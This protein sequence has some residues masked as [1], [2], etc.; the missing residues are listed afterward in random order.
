MVPPVPA[1]TRPERIGATIIISVSAQRS[2]LYYNI[3]EMYI[4]MYTVYNLYDGVNV[5]VLRD[6]NEFFVP[7][8]QYFTEN[9]NV[10]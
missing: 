7:F 9:V 5:Q 1:S 8:F 2:V 3:V 6:V 10:S 4:Y